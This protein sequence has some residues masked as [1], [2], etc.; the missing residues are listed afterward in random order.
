MT[1]RATSI[2]KEYITSRAKTKY[3]K[4]NDNDMDE[5]GDIEKNIKIEITAKA[6][7]INKMA[8]IIV[9]LS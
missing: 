9:F 3:W 7:F 5:A 2:R 1:F 4:D 8:E 6:L